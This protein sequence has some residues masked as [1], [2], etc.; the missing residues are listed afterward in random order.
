MMKKIILW[1]V[2]ALIITIGIIAGKT[3][4]N[5][6]SY[7]EVQDYY[8]IPKKTSD[9]LKIGIIG[10][11]W[12]GRYH[13][14]ELIE[15]K[16]AERG[17][18]AEI[19]AS[20]HPGATSKMIY[21][22]MFKEKSEAF[23]SRFIIEQQPKYCIVI[24]GVNDSSRHIGKEYYAEHL[25]LI[26]KALLH[27]QITPIIMEIPN[28]GIED[29][30]RQKKTLSRYGNAISESLSGGQINNISEYRNELIK[31]LKEN[32]LYDKVILFNPDKAEIGYN[33]NINLYWDSLHLNEQ[34]YEK[35]SNSL[36]EKIEGIIKN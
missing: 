31:K 26:T 3:L 28:F 14:D 33:E 2:A 13:F 15:Q 18:K 35:L 29:N 32:H 6:F 20:S 5:K 27:Y 11:S 19:L 30:Q 1:A 34:G 21:E 9:S 24:A 4:Y 16:L 36:A 8:E 10:D 22:N 12:V 25:I 23:S 7:A 17:I